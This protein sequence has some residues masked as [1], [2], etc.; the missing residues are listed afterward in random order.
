V[1]LQNVTVERSGKGNATGLRNACITVCAHEIVGI[2]GV[3]GNG[4]SDLADVLCGIIRPGTGSYI[5]DGE[6]ITHAGVRALVR[7]GVGRVPEDRH[8]SGIFGDMTIAETLVAERYSEVPF[9][10]FGILRW[11]AVRRFAHDVVSEYKVSCTHI[12]MPAR[13]LSGGNLQKLILGRTFAHKPR[14][15]VANQPTRGL[16][17]GAAA[18]I[19]DRLIAACEGGAAVLLI[20]DDLDEILHMA[21]RIAVMFRGNLSPALPRD[22]VTAEGLGLAMA[23]SQTSDISYAA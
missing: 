23:G 1:S 8:G 17:V 7:R 4:Q 13:A 16:D 11:D 10:S 9:A 20:S 3:S 5:L 12:D 19:H 21:D 18:Y 2:A 14:F 6:D 22:I 15:I